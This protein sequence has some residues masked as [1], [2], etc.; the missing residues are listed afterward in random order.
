[1]LTESLTARDGL[2]TTVETLMNDNIDS[3]SKKEI[4]G[5]ER[6]FRIA[7]ENLSKFLARVYDAGESNTIPAS[8]NDEWC[9]K[10]DEVQEAKDALT[11]IVDPILGSR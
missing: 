2:T 11:K 9:K 1:M 10:C 8:Y 6:R 3:E 7:T 4:L 5:A